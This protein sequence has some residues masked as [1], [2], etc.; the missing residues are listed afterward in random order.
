MRATASMAVWCLVFA[1]TMSTPSALEK[2]KEQADASKMS[3]KE[4]KAALKEY[5]LKCKA[6]S[7]KSEF[8]AML[9]EAKEKEAREQKERCRPKEGCEQGCDLCRSHA[10]QTQA[11]CGAMSFCEWAETPAAE[12][13]AGKGGTRATSNKAGEGKGGS[14][15]ARRGGGAEG[16][17]A[18]DGGSSGS[19]KERQRERERERKAADRENE[20]DNAQARTKAQG[21]QQQQRRGGDKSKGGKGQKRKEQTSMAMFAV[22][23][24]GDAVAV[25]KQIEMGMSVAITD[26]RGAT[27]LHYASWYGHLATVEVLLSADADPNSRSGD[28]FTPLHLASAFGHS[29]VVRALLKAGADSSLQDRDGHT[30]MELARRGS[31]NTVLQVLGEQKS[32]SVNVGRGGSGGNQRCSTRYARLGLCAPDRATEDAMKAEDLELAD[33]REKRRR[34]E[35]EE[36][37]WGGGGGRAYDEDDYTDSEQD[38]GYEAGELLVGKRVRA[39]VGQRVVKSQERKRYIR[40]NGWDD[41]SGGGGGKIVEL[42]DDGRRCMV[43]WSK[44]SEVMEYA[45]GYGGLYDLVAT[46]GG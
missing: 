20:R 8:V 31:H 4:L 18:K 46:G 6:C 10:S 37:S 23:T 17:R 24:S 39:H 35:E 34:A 21:G 44:T 9:S 5:G 14:A 2:H 38:G 7:D 30:S 32:P 27:P 28:G 1:V 33:K 3:V 25:K 45:L 19:E 41:L 40:E 11:V 29:P 26:D 16:G 42:M 15:D 43:K 36:D 12:K 22:A 13:A